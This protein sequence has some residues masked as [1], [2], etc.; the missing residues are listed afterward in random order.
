MKKATIS[1]AVEQEKIRAIKSNMGKS[2]TALEAE[3]DD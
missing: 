1:V 2:G 3:L